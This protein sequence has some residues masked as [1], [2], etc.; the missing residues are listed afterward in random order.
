MVKDS[1]FMM[2]CIDSKDLS[3]IGRGANGTV[4]KYNKA[5]ESSG[6]TAVVKV[7]KMGNPSNAVRNYDLLKHAGVRNLA[8]YEECRVDGEPA[9]LMEDLFNDEWVYVSPN[10]V[11]NG[12]VDNQPED[13]LLQ[14][15]LNDIHNMDT[16][17]L[18]MRDLAFCTNGNGIG[19]DMDMISFGVQKGNKDSDVFYKLV[20]IDVMLHDD[21][22]RHKL[23][24]T[25]IIAAKEAL[26]L[27]VQYFVETD[28]VKKRL[29]QQVKEF[30]W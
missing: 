23:Y 13:Y 24:S 9:I 22:C 10:S 1:R 17:L 29:F 8:F 4:Y 26:T 30:K 20:D 27:F 15:K 19:L 21:K 5:L 6:L 16:L 2:E 25:N 18:Q 7:S 11:R 12:N 14:N 3:Q 28:E